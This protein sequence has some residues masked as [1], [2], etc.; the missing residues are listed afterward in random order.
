MMC[1]QRAG[2]DYRC[3]RASRDFA[4]NIAKSF[5]SSTGRGNSLTTTPTVLTISREWS[6]TWTF[7]PATCWGVHKRVPSTRPLWDWWWWLQ[8]KS[9]TRSEVIKPV[10]ATHA[11]SYWEPARYRPLG[12]TWGFQTSLATPLVSATFRFCNTKNH[13]LRSGVS[14]PKISRCL[15]SRRK[16]LTCEQTW[17]ASSTGGPP[18]D[19][20]RGLGM[21]TSGGGNSIDLDPTFSFC[22]RDISPMQSGK[23]L[24]RFD[25]MA[26]NMREYMR[27]TS[28][29]TEVMLL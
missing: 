16:S 11:W 21:K 3:L 7:K 24:M 22:K 15:Y 25:S 18:G 2:F 23:R 20:P 8:T 9:I 5:G 26:K 19:A 17:R 13:Y 12:R 29:G 27:P 14:L 6:D 1:F 10:D 4:R 28:S